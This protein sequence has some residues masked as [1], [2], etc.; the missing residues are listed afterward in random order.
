MADAAPEDQDDNPH[1]DAVP[2]DPHDPND[3]DNDDEDDDGPRLP[4]HIQAHI[5]YWEYPMSMIIFRQP[6][7]ELN[8]PFQYPP[9]M[10]KNTAHPTPPPFPLNLDD[11][12][13][14]ASLIVLILAIHAEAE[15]GW[16]RESGYLV[17]YGRVIGRAVCTLGLAMGCTVAY[18]IVG[19]VGFNLVSEWQRR[20]TEDLLLRLDILQIDLDQAVVIDDHGD[21]IWRQNVPWWSPNLFWA[22]M[23]VL[24]FMVA[25]YFF[26][27]LPGELMAI[28]WT[29]AVPFAGSVLWFLFNLPATL[30]ADLIAMLPELVPGNDGIEDGRGLWLEYGVPVCIQTTM[31]AVLWLLVLRFRAESER[32][33]MIFGHTSL[34]PKF[35]LFGGLANAT[36]WHLLACTTYQATIAVKLLLESYFA[37]LFALYMLKELSVFGGW[38]F[39]VTTMYVTT[40]EKLM[41]GHHITMLHR[42]AMMRHT[43]P[44]ISRLMAMADDVMRVLS[45]SQ[46]PLTGV[47]IDIDL[48]QSYS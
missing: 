21:A 5:D 6:A 44:G 39:A 38:W 26:L 40:L 41:N 2:N 31:I 4:P 47:N 37:K 16:L 1:P 42:L 34:N 35:V 32:L 48:R 27:A 18:D 14:C 13:Y 29:Y 23:L 19:N 17:Y 43:D 28:L 3:D 33:A 15:T 20:I 7:V 22:R 30:P 10:L 11:F 12:A 8:W 9:E 36:A 24:G 25:D 46:T 45:G